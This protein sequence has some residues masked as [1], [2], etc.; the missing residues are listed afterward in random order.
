MGN[1]IT[2]VDFTPVHIEVYRGS[3]MALHAV[4]EQTRAE[5]EI[6]NLLDIVKCITI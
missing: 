5:N 1:H 4:K 6:F 3:Y 2:Q